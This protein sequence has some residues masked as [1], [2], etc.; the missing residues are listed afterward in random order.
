[1]TSPEL[2]PIFATLVGRQLREMWQSIG[3]P[4]LFQIVE[5]GAGTG[6]LCRDILWWASAAAPEF[7]AT[8][9]YTIVETSSAMVAHQRSMLAADSH[10]SK[11]DWKLE[12]PDDVTGCILSN[13]LLDSFAIRRVKMKN[14]SLAE[15]FVRWSSEAF[16]EELRPIEIGDVSRYFDRL[17]LSPGEG[18]TAEVNLQ[19]LDWMRKAGEALRRGFV[20]T[21]DYGYEASDL[22]AP[23]RTDGTLMCF[24]RHNPSSDPYAR[25][26]RQD[27]TTHIDFTSLITAGEDADLTTVGLTSQNEFL[28]RLG[29]QD[30]LSP[31]A[32][33]TDLEAYYARRGQINELLDPAGLGRVKVLVQSKA[34]SNTPLAGFHGGTDA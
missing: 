16:V 7:H 26:G 19:A 10:H 28:E 27:M 3:E 14:G 5:C 1:M 23:W 25:I 18:C 24:Y 20:M 6:S 8:I 13:E 9:H 32:E 30:A 17:G 22:F 21:F 12:V 34:T 11:V 29:I 33:G 31:P 15:I 2:S 4:T